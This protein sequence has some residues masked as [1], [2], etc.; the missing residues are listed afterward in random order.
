[1]AI[2]TEKAFVL[3]SFDLRETSKIATLYTENSGKIKGI[4]KGIRAGKKNFTTSLGLGTLNEI[5]YYPSRNDLWLVSYADL[6]SGSLMS[7]DNIEQASVLN[8]ILELVDKIMPMYAPSKLVFSLIDD[9]LRS[10]KANSWETIVYIF[11]AKLLEH[12]GFRPSLSECTWCYCSVSKDAFF[13]SRAGG[14]VCK[15]CSAKVS[16]CFSLS[17]EVLISLRYI[18]QNE[19]T[20]ALRLR[21]SASA[22]YEMRRIL[23]EFFICHT[24]TK[25]RSL[26]LMSMI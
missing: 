26:E 4:F 15:S 25:V 20:F 3:K 5:V 14:L 7:V 17:Q 13:S 22:C 1:M 8:Y 18:Q 9:T 16:D 21:P 10:L 19:F 24:N 6:L 11:Q 23:D 2:Q 12:S